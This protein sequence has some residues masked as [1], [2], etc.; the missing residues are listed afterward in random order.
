MFTLFSPPN[1]EQ[2][3]TNGAD[4][5]MLSQTDRLHLLDA[6]RSLIQNNQSHSNTQ[7]E[8]KL[9]IFIIS[10]SFV[11]KIQPNVSTSVKLFMCVFYCMTGL[12]HL[13]FAPTVRFPCQL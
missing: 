13:F 5:Q 3:R 4:K 7:P 9:A 8:T 1:Q 10:T 6:T 2:E 12:F 11:I